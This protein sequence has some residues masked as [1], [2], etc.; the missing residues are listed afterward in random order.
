MIGIWG[1]RTLGVYI[2]AWKLGL[3]LPAVWT[4]IALDNAFRT[5]LFAWYRKK[6]SD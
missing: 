6:K 5:G 1:I 3:G 2:F 4:S